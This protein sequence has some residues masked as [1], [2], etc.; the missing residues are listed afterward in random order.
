MNNNNFTY[1]RFK[2]LSKKQSDLEL[3]KKLL[4][5][6]S[7]LEKHD[8]ENKT[9]KYLGDQYFENEISVD[10]ISNYLSKKQDDIIVFSNETKEFNIFLTEEICGDGIYD[11]LWFSFNSLINDFPKT[12]DL[13]PFFELLKSMFNSF[14]GLYAYSEDEQILQVYFAEKSYNQVIS[15]L[16]FEYQ[17]FVPRPNLDIINHFNIPAHYTINKI[18]IT[19][20]PNGF[21]WINFLSKNQI[22]NLNLNNSENSD[23]YYIEMVNKDCNMYVLTETFLNINSNDHLYKLQNLIIKTELIS[24]Q[25]KFKK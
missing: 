6:I 19:Q 12:P 2:I 24:K 16:P 11:C 9:V 17:K 21:W 23:W 3:S 20:V 14:K 25:E 1:N 15:Q 8:Y 4:A 22:E 10:E 13:K 7:E 18:D 5:V